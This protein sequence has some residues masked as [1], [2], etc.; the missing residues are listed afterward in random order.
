MRRALNITFTVLL[1]IGFILLGVFV[2]AT[3]Y[4][5]FWHGL[6]DFGLSFGYYFCVIFGIPHNIMTGLKAI[7][8]NTFLCCSAAIILTAGWRILRG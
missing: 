7:P 6:T 8:P 2:F 1:T 3:S 5:R 4:I